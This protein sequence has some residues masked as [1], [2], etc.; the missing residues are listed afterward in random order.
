MQ[1]VQYLVEHNR[2]LN[3][4]GIAFI[5]GI[6]WLFSHRRA[7]IN[8]RLVVS[9]L[10]LHF[11][12]ALVLLKTVIGQKAVGIVA[13][14]VS[15]IYVWG[16]AGSSFIF[17]KL[18]DPTGPWG[19]IFA[20]RV[21]P[22]TIFFGAF[23]SLLFHFGI[24]QRVVYWLSLLIRPV[25]K[26]SGAETL[27]AIANSFLGQTEAPLVI[28]NYL[29]NMKR[30]EMLVVMVSGMATISGAILVVF[31]VMG[32]PI[33]H[34]LAS[35]VMSIPASLVIAKILYPETEK[36]QTH[37]IAI[38]YETT[39]SNIFDAIF[40]GTTDGLKLAVNVAAMLV[41]FLALLACLNSF[42]AFC[43]TSLNS[44]FAYLSL[45][46]QLPE[47]SINLF[48]SYLFAPFGYLFGFQGDEIFKVASLLGTK[49]A[50][51]EVIAYGQMVAMGLSERTVAIMT[52]ALCGFS[53]FSCIGIQIGGIGALVPERRA[54]LTEFGLY[55][56]LGGALTNLLSAMVASLLL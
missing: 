42:F 4:V 27:C 2:Y 29:K 20:F 22:V 30:S 23:T 12:M 50:I 26:T 35:S 41:S 54:W 3:L 19:F 5:L 33:Q 44:F 34:L 25:L 10:G 37:D 43:G 55:A 8:L 48:F 14:G 52:Y 31:A 6:A 40:I 1:L 39:S 36:T 32:V 53:N 28:R 56:V 46:F 49:V 51:N 16:D 18:V 24:I 13:S 17:G 47:L 7:H 9:G 15:N 38:S 45:P 11:L 21:L